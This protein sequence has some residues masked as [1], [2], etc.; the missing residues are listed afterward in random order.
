MVTRK[1]FN[2]YMSHWEQIK[3]MNDKQKLSIFN[4]I[5]E[6]QFLEKNIDDIQF[7]DMVTDLVW[8][9]IKHSINT[10][11]SGFVN[12]QKSLGKGVDIPLTKGGETPPMQQCKGEVQ[13]QEE[14]EGKV[15]SV[16]GFKKPTIQELQSKIIEKKYNVDAERFYNHYESN[17]WKVGKNKMKS[18][19]SALANWNKTN[20]EKTQQHPKSF[21]QQDSERI[22]MSVNSY[23]Q[24]RANGFD[25]RNIRSEGIEE[26]KVIEG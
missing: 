1:A 20:Q 22:D 24:A 14:E 3:K 25:L 10:S 6:V 8:T 26:A 18:W 16:A 19:V 4:A 12:K 15:Q 11:I 9:G 21:K 7:K 13:V 23:L 5:C 2:F 17:G